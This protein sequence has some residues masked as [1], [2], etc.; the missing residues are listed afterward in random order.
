VA[1]VRRDVDDQQVGQW[2]ADRLGS[3]V[4]EVLRV[5]GHLSVVR[6][7]RLA[8]GREVAV[9]IRPWQARWAA[10]TVVQHHLWRAGFPCPRPLAG[11]DR[12]GDYAVGAEEA[13]EPRGVEV[14]ADAGAYAGLLADLIRNAPDPEAVPSLAPSP[15][16]IRWHHDGG[17]VWPPPD[18][19]DVDLH[20]HPETAWLDELGAAVRGRLRAGPGARP[21]IGHGDFDSVNVWWRA[22]RALAVHDWDSVVC[23]PEPVIVGQAAAMWAGRETVWG[24]T[25]EQSE[26]F[27]DGYQKAT[28]RV[29][30]AAEV[31]TG[32]AAGLWVR[33]FN[34]KKAALDGLDGLDRDEAAE[35]ARRAGL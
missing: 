8:D 18:D 6:V 4:A 23:E 9:K 17:A 12:F 10:C 21:V 34:A 11:P 5:T 31:Q 14:I 22:G 35:R 20:G 19:R 1:T 33:A 13:V 26:A 27:L 29:W 2:C 3:P 16:W 7:V 15:P 28:G 30:S 24:A 25:V 32:W